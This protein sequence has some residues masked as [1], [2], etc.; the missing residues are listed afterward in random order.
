MRGSQSEGRGCTATMELKGGVGRKKDG[1]R[2]GRRTKGR[3]GKSHGVC[4]ALP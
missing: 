1:R 3:G 4:L 2:G